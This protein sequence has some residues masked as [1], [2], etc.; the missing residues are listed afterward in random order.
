MMG[1]VVPETYWASNKICNKNH[2]L[3]P[4]GILFPHINDDA[5]QN[6]SKW[7]ELL[8]CWIS[9]LSI[10]WAV[11]VPLCGRSQRNIAIISAVMLVHVR[12]SVR[13]SQL[14]KWVKNFKKIYYIV[15]RPRQNAL[16]WLTL[17]WSHYDPSKRRLPL[18]HWHG[19]TFQTTQTLSNIAVISC[20]TVK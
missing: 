16:D 11:E 5:R 3:H 9:D 17:R 14:Q 4:V 20:N 10:L 6:H 13:M 15:N 8:K 1:I 19:V 7:M 18:T 2:L 12:Q